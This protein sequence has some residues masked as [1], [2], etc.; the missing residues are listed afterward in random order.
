MSEPN[1]SRVEKVKLARASLF[2]PKTAASVILK[3]LDSRRGSK[4]GQAAARTA[5]RKTMLEDW[6]GAG[7]SQMLVIQGLDDLIAPK[8]NGRKLLKRKDAGE[9]YQILQRSSI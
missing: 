3:Y 4:D 7:S 1:I 9:S 5:N 8:E 2:S 6:W